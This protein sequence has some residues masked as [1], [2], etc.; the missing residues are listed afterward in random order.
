ML[1]ADELLESQQQMQT[2]LAG[3][4]TLFAGTGT[5]MLAP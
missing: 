2:D 4:A 1:W 3:S 5:A